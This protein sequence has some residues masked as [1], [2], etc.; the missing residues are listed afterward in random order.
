MLREHYV[1][2]FT[3]KLHKFLEI[4]K[5]LHKMIEDER[6]TLNRPIISEEMKLQSETLE[7]RR[8]QVQM[9]SKLNS[10]SSLWHSKLRI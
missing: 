3:N 2:L 4:C 10:R 6:E 5:L 9:A 7:E 1:Q 8:I